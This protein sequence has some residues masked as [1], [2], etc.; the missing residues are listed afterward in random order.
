M[1]TRPEQYGDVVK[2]VD[3]SSTPIARYRHTWRTAL[4]SAGAL[5]LFLSSLWLRSRG[6]L[7]EASGLL[8]LVFL[9]QWFGRR[10]LVEEQY[11]RPRTSAHR[12]AYRFLQGAEVAGILLLLAWWF[13]IAERLGWFWIAAIGLIVGVGAGGWF[14]DRAYRGLLAQ[15]ASEALA[16]K[17]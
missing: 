2:D 12:R 9:I 11:P 13:T 3:V 8:V 17:G 10:W 1:R 16:S 6:R 7:L 5:A 15:V 14:I 4:I